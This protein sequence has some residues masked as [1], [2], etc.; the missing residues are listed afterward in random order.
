MGFIGDLF[1]GERNALLDAAA[2][3]SF[4]VDADSVPPEV[5]GLTAYITPT[6]PA[7]RIDRKTA[8]QVPAVKRVRDLIAGTLGGLPLDLIGPD[9][10]ASY[11]ELLEQPERD[12]PRSV[13]LSRLFE[14]MLFE[15]IGWWRIVEFGWHGY[16]T[17]VKRLEPRS[18]TVDEDRSEVRYRGRV[19]PNDELIRFDS[20]TDALLIAG[21]RA[22]RTC[23][24][25]D[26]AVARYADGAPPLDYFHPVDDVDPLEDD[27]I[28]ETLNAW[29]TARQT[30]STA[31][32]PAALKYETAGWNPEQLQLTEARQS[33]KLEI[34]NVGGVDPEELGISTTSRTY[35]NAFDRRK[36]FT[37]FTL[38]Q[39]RQAF[40]DRMSMGDV[41]PRGYR[42]R[43]NLDAFLRSDPKSRMETYKL[44]LEVGAYTREEI[45]DLEDR[46]ALTEPETPKEAAPVTADQPTAQTFDE[47]PAIRLD[48]PQDTAS[49]EVDAEN[50]VI[51]GLIVPYG[52]VAISNGQ[53][54]Q[55]SQGSLTY[56]D[57]SR[58]KLWI[59]HDKTQ[60][61]GVAFELDDKP[62]GMY[63]AFKVARG[64][65]GDRA[66]SLAE[67][68]VLDGFSIG[69][70]QG[71]KFTKRAGVN[72]AVSAPLME[73]S[74][75]PAPSFDDARVHAVAAAA[76]SQGEIEMPEATE[77]VA[78]PQDFS[79]LTEAITGAVAAGF[80]AVTIPPRETVNAG[81]STF[82]ITEEPLYRFDGVAGQHSLTDDMRA[83]LGG[84]A[85]SR[86]RLD[87]FF[88]EQF[89][90]TTT[91][92]GALN[93]TQNRPELYVNQ[94]QYSRP[95]WEMV[96]T[97]S[98]DDKTP[99][100]IPKFSSASG[101]VGDHTEGTEPTPGS[102]AATSQTVTP[103]GISGKIEVNRE[104]LDQGGSPQADQIIYNEMVNGYY[105]A[106]EARIAAVLAAVAT[107]EVNFAGAVDS[108]LV[109]QLT[110]VLTGLQFVRGGN[111]FTGLALDGQLF[112]ALVEA[113]DTT[114]RKLLPV[115]SPV[116][117]DGQ[118]SG[119]FDRVSIGGLTGRAAWALG[120]AVSSKSYLFV[121]SSVY[122][123]ASA[124]K[125]FD[126]Q[127]QL[128]SVDIAIWGYS[129]A[130]VTRASDVR[131]L[132][133]TTADA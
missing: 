14:D 105:E 116:N 39:Y 127:Y 70:A 92:T 80:E 18:V 20:P 15:G 122:A 31:Y 99:F 95:L 111:R 1:R 113:A 94:L 123:W 7:P 3:P 129:A 109:D 11:A 57:V 86:Q 76:D 114:G 6:S 91:N 13:T 59:Q 38:G 65:E 62:E 88:N 58:V 89:A 45:R 32:V 12:R 124:P 83:A 101:L 131:P 126:F 27:E 87:E 24:T 85:E 125:R 25:L 21:A 5:F 110:G 78:E 115:M 9:S 60:A 130:A 10:K 68:G 41:T 79:A 49:F 22:I 103:T 28:E 71:G 77:I 47:D 107:S 69:L 106:I 73:T 53:R 44:G 67:D 29:Q 52:V 55:F 61:V 97:G 42:V 112:P 102:F 90:V 133:Y 8:I 128:K 19:V 35:N 72:H 16:P 33:A 2:G 36:S 17:K 26:S 48:S 30:R 50:R 108:A 54:W 84:D 75:T 121:P 98:I 119:A 100:T 81:G 132:D 63:G 118:T 96:T 66:L 104:V 34:A 93:P 4:A 51:R 74:L 120:S 23:L 82:E 117:A 37:D 40:E 43:Q 46:P 56:G 64:P